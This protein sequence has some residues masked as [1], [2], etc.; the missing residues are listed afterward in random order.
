MVGSQ[1]DHRLRG[2]KKQWLFGFLLCV[3]CVCLLGSL[4]CAPKLYIKESYRKAYAVYV[5][6]GLVSLDNGVVLRVAPILKKENVT[7]PPPPTK[8]ADPAAPKTDEEKG[9][10][11]QDREEEPNLVKVHVTRLMGSY[12]LAGDGFKKVWMIRPQGE[13]SGS[14]YPLQVP[15][16]SVLRGVELQVREQWDCVT[17]ILNKGVGG[18]FYIHKSGEIARKCND[19]A[20]KPQ[21]K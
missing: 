4:G 19:K 13:D 14:Y 8:A 9:K 15:N 3:W 2:P 7:P 11:K 21:A 6:D 20:K 5:V 17:L 12:I 18:R 1:K 16:V 10:E